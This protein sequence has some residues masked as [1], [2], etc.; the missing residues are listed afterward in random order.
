[1]TRIFCKGQIKTVLTNIVAEYAKSRMSNPKL[2][3]GKSVHEYAVQFNILICN[4]LAE[5]FLQ[6][7]N[8]RVKVRSRVQNVNKEML[9]QAQ[10]SS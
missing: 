3:H 4:F 10:S 5:F 9:I 6:K 7:E 1:M 8:Q 2:C